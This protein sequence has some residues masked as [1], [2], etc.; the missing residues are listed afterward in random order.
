MRLSVV[1][2]ARDEPELRRCVAALLSGDRRAGEVVVIDDGSVDPIA[3]LGEGV[4]VLREPVAKGPASARNRGAATTSGDILV[5]VDADVEVGPDTLAALERRL[6]AG[7]DFGAIQ[8]V[9]A[10]EPGIGGFATAFQNLLQHYNFVSISDPEDFVGLSSYCVAVRREAFDAAGGF[11]STITRATVEDDNL[12]HALVQNGWRIVV[13]T[14]IEV[15]HLA[16]FTLGGIS[17]RMARMASDKVRSVRRDPSR[18]AIPPH[19]THHRPGFLLTVVLL[20]ASLVLLP[21]LP[22]VGV[23]LLV[24]VV[25][26]Q[27]PFL[28]TVLARRGPVFAVAST[29]AVLL[30]ALAAGLGS[31]HGLV[32]R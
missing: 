15:R 21:I 32:R 23:G 7:P 19:K 30:L 22:P 1:I 20:P 6:N 31:V 28:R 3:D 13:A 25:G 29:G 24:V 8:T 16:R 10:P 17:R 11:D 26:L 27:V 18:G 12:G 9:Y 14:E 4:I 2:P 5:F